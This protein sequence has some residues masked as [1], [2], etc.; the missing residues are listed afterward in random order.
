MGVNMDYQVLFNVAFMLAGAFGGFIL[1]SL[2]QTLSRLDNDVRAIPKDYV[3]KADFNR[4]VDEL[5]GSIRDGFEQVERNFSAVFRK[6]D[7]KADKSSDVA[8]HK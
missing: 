6:L 8:N 2:T 7:N 4:A 1:N 3:H 5:R